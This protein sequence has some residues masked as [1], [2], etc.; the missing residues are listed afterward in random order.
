VERRVTLDQAGLSLDESQRALYWQVAQAG[1]SWRDDLELVWPERRQ[2]RQD[3]GLYDNFLAP[4]WLVPRRGPRRTRSFSRLADRAGA[5]EWPLSLHR[6]FV[7]VNPTPDGILSFANRYGLLGNVL[8]LKPAGE[9]ITLETRTAGESLQD[10]LSEIGKA[11]HLIAAWDLVRAKD[12]SKL[13]QYIEWAAESVDWVGS[14]SL[15]D[16]NELANI[17]RQFHSGGSPALGYTGPAELRETGWR[18]GE[19]L[20]PATYY[21]AMGINKRLWHHTHSLLIPFR[22]GDIAPVPVDLL[23]VIYTRFAQEVAGGGAK[24]EPCNRCGALFE[25][26]R[27]DHLYCSTACRKARYYHGTVKPKKNTTLSAATQEAFSN[28]EG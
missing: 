11:R 27:S 21:V 22:R 12:E 23:G 9:P 3:Q 17:A 4:P 5:G 24:R 15:G 19:V 26:Q 13:R 28:D 8:A 20:R 7:D 10:W 14:H 2:A 1:Y 25:P 16:E 6:E 18:R